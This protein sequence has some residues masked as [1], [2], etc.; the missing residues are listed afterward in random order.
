MAAKKRK[1]RKVKKGFLLF[2]VITGI[3]LV[4]CLALF[5]VV[6]YIPSVNILPVKQ[7][8]VTGDQV[9]P[10]EQIISAS[11][12]LSGKS[13]F[14][15]NLNNL[16]K[17]LEKE[18]PYVKKATISY[19]IDG[20]VNIEIVATEVS[21]SVKIN[22]GYYNLDSDFKLLENLS[23]EKKGKL[24]YGVKITEEAQVGGIVVDEND[25]RVELLGRLTSK[26]NEFSIVT[27]VIDLEDTNNILFVYKGRYLV[28][29]GD[30]SKLEEKMMMFITID[31]DLPE[32]ETGRI[33][34][35]LWGNDDRYSS[36][37]AENIDKY[38]NKY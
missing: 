9:Y 21:Y 11:G 23:Q 31:K 13:V 14:K 10:A 33:L 20:T 2:S 25:S 38:I 4:L 28:E 30:D 27:D 6:K 17:R 34:L 22:D 16:E 35:K 12:L 15:Y 1:K 8:S 19:S 7:I 5:V 32:N 18:L 26:F 29:L 36:V 37:I 24:I 3:I